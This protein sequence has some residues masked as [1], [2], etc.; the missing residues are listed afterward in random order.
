MVNHSYASLQSGDLLRLMNYKVTRATGD[1]WHKIFG[2]VRTTIRESAQG[3]CVRHRIIGNLLKMYD[4]Q[5]SVLRSECL[6]PSR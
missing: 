3:T 1:P 2:E 5:E 4:K 6:A